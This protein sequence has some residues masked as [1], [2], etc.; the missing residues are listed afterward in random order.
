MYGDPG[1]REDYYYIEPSANGN[2]A[3]RTTLGVCVS[4]DVLVFV[5]LLVHMYTYHIMLVLCVFRFQTDTSCIL[6]IL[7]QMPVVVCV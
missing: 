7:K 4:V 2:A 1:R 5:C 6:D 3:V